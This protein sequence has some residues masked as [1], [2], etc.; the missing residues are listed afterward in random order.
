MGRLGRGPG[1]SE[2]RHSVGNMRQRHARHFGGGGVRERAALR[3][4]GVA[5]SVRGATS[6]GGGGW[7]HVVDALDGGPT[8]GGRGLGGGSGREG[9]GGQE[10]VMGAR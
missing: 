9:A 1:A 7:G 10:R 4:T 8:L 2:R 6:R 5:G 3:S